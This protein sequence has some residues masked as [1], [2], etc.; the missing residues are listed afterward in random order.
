MIWAHDNL[1]LPGTSGSPASA[2]SVAGIAG[3]RHY[4]QLIFVLLVETEFHHVGQASLELLTPGDPP[5]L[6]FQPAG[7]LGEGDRRETKPF[8]VPM[9]EYSG[10]ILAHCNLYFPGSSNSHASVSQVA[11]ITD[12]SSPPISAS[13]IPGTTSAHKHTWLI[14]LETR[15]CR[16]AWAVLELLCCSDPLTSASQSLALSPRLECNG[17]VIAHCNLELLDSSNPPASA[18]Q[19]AGLIGAHHQAHIIFGFFGRD[20]I[21]LCCPLLASSGLPTWSPE[22]LGL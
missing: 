20:R 7:V 3:T 13:Q 16:V 6:A 2:S 9:L 14:S 19:I 17:T 21:L 12:S 10:M 22:V 8:S 15:F 4:A 5:T 11:G 18:S 1:H